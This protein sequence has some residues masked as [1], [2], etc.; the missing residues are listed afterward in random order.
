MFAAPS[1]YHKGGFYKQMGE[2]NE[3]KILDKTLAYTLEDHIRTICEKNEVSY[4]SNNKVKNS[5]EK[6][7]FYEIYGAH[8]HDTGTRIGIGGRH[9]AIKFICT[10]YFFKYTLDFTELTDDERFERVLEYD[11]I[12]CFPSLYDTDPQEVLDLWNWIKKTFRQKREH[13]REVREEEKN[14]EKEKAR[15]QASSATEYKQYLLA[16]Y[17]QSVRQAL[18]N[19]IWTQISNNPCKFIVG[20]KRHKHV[21]RAY[22]ET[23]AVGDIILHNLSFGTIIFKCIPA[24]IIKHENPLDFLNSQ[25]TYTISFLNQANKSFTLS[26]MTL[27]QI[28]D[29]L[30]NDGYIMPGNGATEVLAAMITAFRDD[31]LMNIDKSVD[32]EGYYYHNGDIQI[33]KVNGK[34]PRRNKEQCVACLHF[35]DNLSKFYVWKYKKV[36]IDRRDFLASAIKWTIPA[37]FNFVIK[38]LTRKYQKGFDMTGER[39]GGKSEMAHLMLDMHGNFV[40]Q[41]EE[42]IYSLSSGSM[43]TEAK[44][45]KGVSKSTYPIEISEFGRIEG[46]GRNENMVETVKVAIEK[47]TVRRGRDGGRYDVLF[48]SLSSII[49][50]GNPFISKKGEILKRLHIVKF[51]EEDRHQSN[52]PRTKEFADFIKSNRHKLKILGDWTVNY[53][54]D[55]RHELMLSKKYDTYQ[56]SDIVLRK[57]Y[58]FAGVPFPE[59]LTKWITETSLEELDTDEESTIRSVLFDYVHKTIQNN[60]RIFTPMDLGKTKINLDAR[61]GLCI[62]NDLSSFVRKVSN[63]DKYHIDSSI[64]Q[65][66]NDKLPELTLKKLGEK[67][68][69]S[70]KTYKERRV[71]EF[72]RKELMDFIIDKHQE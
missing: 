68:G 26:R 25:I 5:K 36:D 63:Q 4:F 44:F 37:P 30:R 1:P 67:M 64:L 13:D 19:D 31:N 18:G 39:D 46:Y 11:K 34:H 50:N 33:S 40:D 69:F 32:F 28:M 27:N 14:R 60:A 71:L 29:E 48:P 24:T 7:Q 3:I 55:N 10:S 47:L 53:I 23:S 61:I 9:E 15:Q 62:D 70:Y 2:S 66:F 21:C 35:I 20:E 12:H 49:L 72:S 51:S 42:S 16:S 22:V 58:E 54:L 45:G 59:W 6:T 43:N 52:D 57:F 38:Q 65:L 56:I 17:P 41:D 8:L